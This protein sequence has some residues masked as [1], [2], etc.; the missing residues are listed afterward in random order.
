MH[1]VRLEQH[2]VDV[3]VIVDNIEF[4]GGKVEAPVAEVAIYH[5]DGM[6]LKGGVEATTLKDFAKVA[7]GV[8]EVGEGAEDG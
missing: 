4:G 6:V 7:N 1:H 8:D 2:F 5:V 3:P